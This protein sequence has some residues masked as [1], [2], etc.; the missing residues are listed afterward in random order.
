MLGERLLWM[1][2]EHD[3]TTNTLDGKCKLFA[4]MRRWCLENH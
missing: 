4:A 3:V 1:E 2:L